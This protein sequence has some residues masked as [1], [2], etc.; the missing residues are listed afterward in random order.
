VTP[1]GGGEVGSY[2]TLKKLNPMFYGLI[3]LI[4]EATVDFAR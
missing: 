4:A 2:M 1:R 3:F